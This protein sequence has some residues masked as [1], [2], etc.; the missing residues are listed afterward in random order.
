MDLKYIYNCETCLL[1][2][3]LEFVLA[4]RLDIHEHQFN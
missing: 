2:P 4:V 3:D 1:L